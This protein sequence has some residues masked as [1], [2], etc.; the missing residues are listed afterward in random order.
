MA[1]RAFLGARPDVAHAPDGT[2][3]WDF[4]SLDQCRSEAV[5]RIKQEASRRI[6]GLF[7][8]LTREQADAKK[9]NLTARAVELVKLRL[10]R[11]WTADEQ[12]E[13]DAGQPLWDQIKAIR[14]ASDEAEDAV[15]AAESNAA[16]D[17]VELLSD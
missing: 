17:A 3:Q 8:G 11:D 12:A 9:E 4:R 16:V 14:A 2:V 15:A 13:W 6:Y 5:A 1:Y 10:G 7:A